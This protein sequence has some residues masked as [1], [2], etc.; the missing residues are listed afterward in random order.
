MSAKEA[1]K[2]WDKL[3]LKPRLIWDKLT[4]AQERSVEEVAENYK[5]F[6]D[7]GRTE[8]KVVQW[9]LKA[10]H[11]A[12]FKE[13]GAK[14]RRLVIIHRAKAA[15]LAW[16]GQKPVEEGL[17]II[18]AHIDCPRL[19]F[20]TMPLYEEAEV[21]FLKSQY[22]G[23]IKK[24]QW[25]A[26]ALGL[27]GVAIK[28]DGLVV[29]IEVGFEPG[30]PV[31]TVADLL[32]HLSRKVQAE[33][34]VSEAFEGEKLNLIVG[35]RPVNNPQVKD[36][37]KLQ[38]LKLLNERFGLVEAD[39][40]SAELEAV[41]ADKPRDVGFDRA[42][43]GGYGHDDRVSAYQ[44]LVSSLENKNPV[45][46]GICLLIDKEETGSEGNTGAKSRFLEYVTAQLLAAA[47][48]KPSAWAVQEALFNSRALSADVAPAFDPDYP[49]VH[50]KRNA[51]RMGYGPCL[52]KYT[53]SGGK[54]STSDANA[55]YI[56]WLRGILDRAKVIWQAGGLGKVDEG[57]GGTIAKYL[58][59]HGM[60]V[61][62]FGVPVLGMHSPF[63][64]ISKADLFMGLKAM[65]AFWE[66]N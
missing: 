12:G 13:P 41:P 57:G 33:K 14:T 8:R 15:A 17:R 37:F 26:R 59:E 19:D 58:A 9:I 66:A 42:L 51:A 63:E 4:L 24:Y 40:I 2:M 60:E 39:L 46:P 49:E 45:R 11:K 62:D 25:L 54:Y 21:V 55:E 31:F 35:S 44:A 65:K 53:G 27:V 61:V 38:V 22:Y 1:K 6:L 36:R 30:D 52:V 50:E 3:A 7:F 32:P 28:A 64:L 10:A 47:G 43:I 16:L 56:A 34:K 48:R 20:K 5:E 29:P 23:G 18:G